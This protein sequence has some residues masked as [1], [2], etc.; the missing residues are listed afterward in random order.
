[1]ADV[2]LSELKPD[3]LAPAAVEAKAEKLG[4]GKANMPVGKAFLS[5]ILAGMFIGMGGMF[6]LL[7]KSD[8]TLTFAASSLLG[9]LAFALGLFLVI[10]AGSELFTGNCLMIMGKMSSKYSWGKLLKSWLVV[11]VGNFCGALI[12]IFLLYFGNFYGMNG[13]AVGATMLT[14]AAGK[15]APSWIVLFF[16]GIMCNILVCLAVWVGFSARTV[17]DKF[18]TVLLPIIA[19]VACGFEHCVA[20]MF[21]L[22]MG[23]VIKSA[24]VVNVANITA[25]IDVITLA[26]VFKNISAATLGNIVGGCIFVGVIYWLIYA[27]KGSQK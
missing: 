18:F 6:M 16:K 19:F 11:W 1:M 27:K 17:V 15:I 26:G 20:N 12:L 25:N 4:V 5:S 2:D 23:L 7:V 10:T 9:G 3:A 22:P 13:G 8:S 21:F 14:V 24:G